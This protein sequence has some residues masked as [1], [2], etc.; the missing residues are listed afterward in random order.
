MPDDKFID[1]CVGID[2][3]SNITIENGCGRIGI[4]HIKNPTI[5]L[6]TIDNL[7]KDITISYFRVV[8]G[9]TIRCVVALQL[10]IYNIRSKQQVFSGCICD[11][12]LTYDTT[13]PII[14]IIGD[15]YKSVYDKISRSVIADFGHLNSDE[16]DTVSFYCTQLFL[17]YLV[18]IKQTVAYERI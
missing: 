8:V 5:G 17:Y 11:I 4:H 9:T 12:G 7:N 10:Q 16:I 2:Q 18:K 13:A 3:L 6:P 1:Y 15:V 14:T